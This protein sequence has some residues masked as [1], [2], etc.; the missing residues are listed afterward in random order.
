MAKTREANE[1]MRAESRGKLLAS[2][3]REFARRGFDAARISDIAAAAGMSTGSLYSHFRTKEEALAEIV[4]A[5]LRAQTEM[6][7]GVTALPGRAGERLDALADRSL[8][9]LADPGVRL[10]LRAA[11]DVLDR[12]GIDRPAAWAEQDACLERIFTAAQR[13][14]ALAAGSTPADL[15]FLYRALLRGLAQEEQRGEQ[16]AARAA[17]LRLLGKTVVEDNRY[18]WKRSG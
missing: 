2:A 1:R 8:A 5:G 18:K 3:A 9:L 7:A 17:L 12:L 11:P 10:A 15:M 6:L 4:R 16:A 13:E 14:G